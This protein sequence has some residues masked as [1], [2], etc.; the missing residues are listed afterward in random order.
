MLDTIESH[1]VS[2][3]EVGAF[4]SGGIDSSAIVSLMRQIGKDKIKT[5][6]I[7]F[8]GNKL[9]ESKYAKIVA[10][11]FGTDH[12]E[13]AL[14]EDELIEDFDKIMDA[15]DQPTIDGVNSYFVSKVAHNFG[16][17]VV[18]SGLGGDELFGG[19]SSFNDIPRYNRIKNIP[20]AKSLMKIAAPILKH[21]LP[22]K[23]YEFMKKPEEQNSID[24]LVKIKSID[25][26]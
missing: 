8:P 26:I 17:K 9:D 14:T 3:V 25:R 22:A 18:M 7:I 10:E 4:L 19:Y 21:I 24:F 2:D 16:L 23:A 13:Y 11:K 12:H 20:F 1:C 6:S 15:M 5:I